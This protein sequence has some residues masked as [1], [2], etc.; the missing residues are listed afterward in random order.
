M[1]ADKEQ[2]NAGNVR[3]APHHGALVEQVVV[4]DRSGWHRAW[5]LTK[6]GL[7]LLIIFLVIAAAAIWIWR[8]VL[9]VRH[10][11]MPSSWVMR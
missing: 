3:V 9:T 7:L 11:S 8:T 5:R 10:S 6:A 1:S 2:G 4:H